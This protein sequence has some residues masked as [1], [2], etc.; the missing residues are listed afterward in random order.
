MSQATL[1][2]R[3]DKEVKKELEEFCGAVG[4]NVSVAVNLFAKAVIREQRLPFEIALDPSDKARRKVFADVK[5]KRNLSKE[6]KTVSELMDDL[7]A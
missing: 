2:I 1:S 6:F 4:M 5:N 7:N 3:M